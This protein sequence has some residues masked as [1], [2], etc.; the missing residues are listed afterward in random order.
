MVTEIKG[1]KKKIVKRKA[2]IR[3]TSWFT[4][5]YNDD[6]WYLVR[7]TPGIGDFTGPAGKPTPMLPHEVAKILV[8]READTKEKGPKLEDR[9]HGR[10]SR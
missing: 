5:K 7:E 4:W 1:G 2:S 9:F 10:R 6:T 8:M 3:A